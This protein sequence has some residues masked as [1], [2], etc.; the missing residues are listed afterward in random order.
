[1]RYLSI[2][3]LIVNTQLSKLLNCQLFIY[4]YEHHYI[5]H[6]SRFCNFL[7]QIFTMLNSVFNF[8]FKIKIY[9]ENV[10]YTYDKSCSSQIFTLLRPYIFSPL[11]TCSNEPNVEFLQNR[12]DFDN[13]ICA[14]YM[15]FLPLELRGLAL[16]V[17][18]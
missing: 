12:F 2:D 14:Y 15:G 18:P 11:T 17:C 8:N 3:N 5:N 10:L 7:S 6:T 4:Q 13:K 1:M 9:G 16:R